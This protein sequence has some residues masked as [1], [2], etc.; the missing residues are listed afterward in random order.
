MR[1]YEADSG[2]KLAPETTDPDKDAD[3]AAVIAD[4]KEFAADV[5]A[6]AVAVLDAATQAAAQTEDLI[7]D[8]DTT[9]RAKVRTK[10]DGVEQLVDVSKVIASY[11]KGLAADVRLAEATEL[12]RDAKTK[13]AVAG[14]EKA[15]AEAGAAVKAM[16]TQNAPVAATKLFKE[17]SDALFEGDGE[18]AAKLFSEAVAAAQPQGRE[19]PPATLNADD[20][21]QVVE[22]RISQ[23]SAL[24]KLFTD[25]PEIKADDDLAL[26]ADR[27]V[28]LYVK[29]GSSQ[30]EAILKA[31]EDI[32]EKFKLGKHKAST[33][34]PLKGDA[35]TTREDKL[36]GKKELD[37]L[38]SSGVRSTATEEPPETPEA[39]IA[40]MAAARP[41]ARI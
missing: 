8:E 30:A 24:E 10:V 28:N 36:A 32:G 20:I 9:K 14:M 4:A 19:A 37:A 18:K 3:I 11:Q 38:P 34:R 16:E 12:L 26:L 13:A 27:R 40:A 22:Q 17:A 29:Q 2:L 35:P 5:N 15:V 33:G 41:G 23:K 21:A 6:E 25:Y 31:S 39:L 7:L 1:N